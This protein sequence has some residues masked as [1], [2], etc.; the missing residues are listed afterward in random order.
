MGRDVHSTLKAS[1]H[2]LVLKT[3]KK[4]SRLK[5]LAQPVG[6]M[7][8]RDLENINDLWAISV[9]FPQKKIADC[10]NALS[11]PK[12]VKGASLTT[13]LHLGAESPFSPRA[14]ITV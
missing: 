13:W 7:R 2:I 12:F 10:R 9:L 1:I 3:K 5:E 4:N 11:S 8:R 14:A 6:I